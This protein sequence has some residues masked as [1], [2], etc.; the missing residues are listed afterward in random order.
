MPIEDK[1]DEMEG[2]VWDMIKHTYNH[3]VAHIRIEDRHTLKWA[4][5]KLDFAVEHTGDRFMVHGRVLA[6][7]SVIHARTSSYFTFFP[8]T[9]TKVGFDIEISTAQELKD[10]RAE[11]RKLWRIQFYREREG[12]LAE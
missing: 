12:A 3:K 10:A 9:V 8:T 7:A 1:L 2:L 4:Q 5:S 11:L 6:S